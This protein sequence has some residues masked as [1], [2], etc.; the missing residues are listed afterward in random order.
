MNAQLESIFLDAA[1]E[2]RALKSKDESAK[3]ILYEK[4]KYLIYS[5]K[6][7]SETNH[8]NFDSEII[9]LAKILKV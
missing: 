3:Y 4:Y 1:R 6:S 5:L 7:S 9:K 2:Y 8:I